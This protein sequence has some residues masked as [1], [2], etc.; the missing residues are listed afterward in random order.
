LFQGN[1]GGP[2]LTTELG[3][4]EIHDSSAKNKNQGGRLGRENSGVCII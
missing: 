1:G 4:E 2:N 3:D